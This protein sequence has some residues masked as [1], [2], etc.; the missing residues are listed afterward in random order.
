MK[1]ITLM[2][3]EKLI[4]LVFILIFG[5]LPKDAFSLKINKIKI[6]GNS[7]T[8]EEI[9]LA[10]A[11][12]FLSDKEFS[13]E[14]LNG[15][16]RRVEERLKNTTW[17]YS[18]RVYIVPSARGEEYRNVVIEVNEGFLLRFSGGYAYGMAGMDNIWGNGEKIF[19]YLGY[20]RQG[21]DF[22]LDN[23]WRNFFA[24]G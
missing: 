23:L 5:P 3:S 6:E 17:F 15:I 10:I 22:E 7:H 4:L 2:K 9:I 14:E 8:K 16:A 20:N 1:I 13:E 18:S 12:E 24:N 21:I 19:L 11:S